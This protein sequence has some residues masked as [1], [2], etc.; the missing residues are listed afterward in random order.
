MTEASVL[1][2]DDSAVMRRILCD[3]VGDEPGL[4]VGGQAENGAEAIKALEAASFD[5]IFLDLEMPVMDGLTALKTIKQRWKAVPVVVFSSLTSRGS[6]ASV[7]ALTLGAAECV[8]KPRTTSASATRNEISANLVPVAN[9]LVDKGRPSPTAA[10]PG[11]APASSAP[12]TTRPAKNV[13]PHLV[14]VA[15]STGGPAAL[16]DLITNLGSIDV[17]ML[18]VQH[19]PPSFTAQLARRLADRSGLDIAEAADGETIEPGKIRLAPGG[20]HLELKRQA[21][22]RVGCR[23]H[24]G[25]KVQYVR[26][27]A[28]VL[29]RSAAEASP[30]P[31]LG[32]V[33]TGMGA[34]GANGSEAI[35]EQGGE[36]IAQDEASSVVWGMP[37]AV[38]GRGLANEVLPLA[39]IGQAVRRRAGA[40]ASR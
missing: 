13:K 12:T 8:L 37:G 34:D 9:A 18:I 17:P 33:L 4:K 35:V 10:R 30:G 24:S 14:T 11:K 3:V 20:L 31:V 26:P 1:I 32:V 6:V 23:L 22:G 15:S 19:I 25:P 38:V 7:Q 16:M 36:I 28:D 2:V 5:L 27:A 40:L 21:S 29:F 39:E